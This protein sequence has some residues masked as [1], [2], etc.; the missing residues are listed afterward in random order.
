[1]SDYIMKIIPADFTYS[2][3]GEQAKRTLSFLRAMVKANDITFLS[4]ETPV[5]VD[6]GSNLEMIVCPCCG[7]Q[8]DFGWWGEA[9]NIAGKEEF[10][11]LSITMPCCGE[12]STLNDL[13][14]EFPCG[15]ACAE[16]DILNPSTD[17]DSQILSEVEELVG[18]PV[19]VIRAHV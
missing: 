11:N 9:M 18:C 7:E 12:K 13:D 19:R 6:C 17:F 1:M 15:F 5:F 10:K 14:Y 8:L 4:S 2:V 3:T 16:F